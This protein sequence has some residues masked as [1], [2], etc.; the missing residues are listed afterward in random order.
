MNK[1][2]SEMNG[3]NIRVFFNDGSTVDMMV[4]APDSYEAEYRASYRAEAVCEKGVAK[5]KWI[6]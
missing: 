3:F 4:Y 5:T 1:G 6:K 2:T